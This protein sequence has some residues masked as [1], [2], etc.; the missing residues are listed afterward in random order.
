MHPS[1]T[2]HVETVRQQYTA[3]VCLPNVFALNLRVTARKTETVE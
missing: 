2:P 1:R 3:P